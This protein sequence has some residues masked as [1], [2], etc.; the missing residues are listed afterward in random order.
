MSSHTGTVTR[1]RYTHG[2]HESVL[3]SHRWRTAENSAAYLSPHLAPG[4]CLLD[5]GCGPGTLTADLA[6]LV[7]PGRV[8]AVEASQAVLDLA[9]REAA[10]RGVSIDFLVADVHALDLPDASY[11]VVHAHQVLQHLADPVG[12]LR[13]MRR[14]C[15]P[16]GIVAA[17][18]SD[19]AAF[20]WYPAVPA[21]DEWLALYRRVVR[22]N[23][24]EPDA[25]RRLLSWAR[26][27]GFTDITP[28]ASVWCFATPDD[29]RWWGESW[30]RRIVESDLAG[31]AVAAGAATPADLAQIAEGWLGW[32][33]AD[34]GWF[35][36][37]HG[38][39]LARA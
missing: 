1:S 34:D 3:H 5:V 21:L 26:A 7:S 32:A 25:G 28:S 19:F 20:A 10:D 17:R 33:D 6:R 30:A 13:E 31:Q 23:G 37:V 24:G 2:H 4:L 38:E 36:V 15:R 29:R 11:D 16:G 8:T 39:I 18:D 9:R 27:A 35:A 14:V 22:G 12:A